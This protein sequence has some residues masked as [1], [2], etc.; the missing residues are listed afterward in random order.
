M[1]KKEIEFKVV[2][3]FDEK[4]TTPDDVEA[5]THAIGRTLVTN[6][7]IPS[8]HQIKDLKVTEKETPN[9]EY[10]SISV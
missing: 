5:I 7:E 3:T 4:V 1:G 6:L 2:L 10:H 9:Y 8:T